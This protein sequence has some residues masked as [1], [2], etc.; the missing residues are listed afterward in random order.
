MK[1]RGYATSLDK[2]VVSLCIAYARYPVRV[3]RFLI[4][5]LV[6]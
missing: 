3:Q 4:L 5:R 6:C 2:R 1:E